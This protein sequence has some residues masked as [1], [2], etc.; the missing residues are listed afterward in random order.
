[1]AVRDVDHG[2][3][4]RSN[5]PRNRRRDGRGGAGGTGVSVNRQRRGV[6]QVAGEITSSSR[7]THASGFPDAS[8]ENTGRSLETARG[9]RRQ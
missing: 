7:Q 9:G 6:E 2:N 4:G 5:V 3:A 1:M 8:R